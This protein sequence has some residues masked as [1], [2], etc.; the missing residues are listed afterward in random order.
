MGKSPSKLSPRKIPAQARSRATVDAI[1]Q[2]ATY[3]LAERGWEGFTTNA[4]AERAGVNIGSLYQ[5]F[6]NKQAVIAEL[7]HRHALETR[8]ALQKV[9]KLPEQL[10]L[11]E[12][13][14]AIFE[15]LINKHRAAPAIHKAIAEEL[16]GTLRCMPE[17]KDALQPQILEYL[18]PFIRNVP[19]PE[20]A[21]YIL[22]TAV[23]AVI[24]DV[25]N[26]QPERLEHGDFVDELVTLFENFLCRPAEINH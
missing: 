6:P 15:M 1:I 14:T 5:F 17:D 22:S 20:M 21:V 18:R 11:R 9:L 26:E 3:I 13:L 10:S 8:K 16:P 2:A 12:A 19:D 7:Q 4:I 25:T 24:H 23:A